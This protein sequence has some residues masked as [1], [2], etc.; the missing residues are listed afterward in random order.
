[1]CLVIRGKIE[2]SSRT[3]YHWG[4]FGVRN[5]AGFELM[6]F[7]LPRVP[8]STGACLQ[9]CSENGQI[10]GSL[11]WLRPEGHA[12]CAKINMLR[13]SAGFGETFQLGRELTWV[14]LAAL[15]Y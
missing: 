5:H 11:I 9:L 15:R 6:D 13:V 14:A 8:V 12:L 7:R 3:E 2:K 4:G 10:E 1:M